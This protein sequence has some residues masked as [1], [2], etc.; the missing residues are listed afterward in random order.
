MGQRWILR[1][2]ASNLGVCELV[3]GGRLI[4]HHRGP[5]R[6]AAINA[7]FAQQ[8]MTQHAAQTQ[9]L[10]FSRAQKNRHAAGGKQ[11]KAVAGFA[12]R[13]DHIARRHFPD[14]EIRQKSIEQGVVAQFG[15]EPFIGRAFAR[16][17]RFRCVE[18]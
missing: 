9:F 8:R 4:D 2:H 3:N 5:A 13:E 6:R 14:R 11:I 16:I 17:A 10:A 18:Q 7:H 12:L 15:F 1:L